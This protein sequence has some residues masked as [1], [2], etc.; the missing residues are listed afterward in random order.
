[1]TALSCP[2]Y[3]A[4]RCQSCRWLDLPYPQQIQQ[5]QQHL[6]QILAPYPVKAYESAITSP[7][8]AFR[9][10]AKMV[11]LGAAHQPLLGIISPQGE[12]TSLVDCPLYSDTMQEVLNYLEQ[13]IQKAGIPPYR[14]DKQKG[15]LKY[16]LLTQSQASG[17]FLLRFVLR[18]ENALARIQTHLDTLLTR[19][20]AI[21]VVSANIQPIHMAVLEGEHEIFLTEAKVLDEQFNDVPL[22]IRPKSFFQTNPFVAAQL[23]QTAR[24]WTRELPVTHVWDLFCGVGGFGLH[25]ATPDTYLTGIEI[26]AEAIECAKQSAQ[27][28]GLKHVTFKTLDSGTFALEQNTP[29]DLVIVNPPRRGIGQALAQQLNQFAPQAIL[30]SSCNPETLASDLSYLD[31][32][33]IEKVQLFD[34]FPHTAHYEVLCLLVLHK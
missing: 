2:H 16:I 8:H 15:E 6:E 18:S 14:I 31:R 29:P 22:K 30:Y 13:W 11:A 28:L 17:E 9:N 12:H 5:K 21:K 23:Y 34:M 33:R 32:Y 24:T 20:S 4:Q 25:C 26:E 19:F 10:K 3:Q 27:Q 1:M 7:I